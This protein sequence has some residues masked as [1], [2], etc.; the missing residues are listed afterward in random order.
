MKKKI[1]TTLMAGVSLLLFQHCSD[2]FLDVKPSTS[3]IVPTSL[4]D[5]ENLLDNEAEINQSGGLGQLSADEYYYTNKMHWEAVSSPS[6]RNAYIWVADLYEGEELIRDWNIPY[7]SIFYANSA[8]ETLADMPA[9]DRDSAYGKYLRGRALFTRAFA[10]FDLVKNFCV[11]YSPATADTDL[12]IPIRLSAGMDNIA[13]RSSLSDSYNAI[14][15]DLREAL[16]YLPSRF[17]VEKRNRPSGVACLALLARIYHHMGRY[18]LAEEHAN[19]CLDLY[20]QL[21]DYNA[22]DVARVNPFTRTNDEVIL[23]VSQVIGLFSTVSSATS[24]AGISVDTVLLALYEPDDLRLQA[25][26]GKRADGYTYKKPGYNDGNYPFTGLATDELYLI[27]AECLARRGAAAESMKTLNHLLR[28]RYKTGSYTQRHIVNAAEALEIVLKERR[29]ELVWRGIR[30][31]DLKRLN[32]EGA[33][34]SLKR[35]MD[36][37]SY[38]LPANSPRWVFPI[39]DAEINLSG[40]TQN[41]R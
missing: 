19:A 23:S 36:G 6:A 21:I 24:N 18:N 2:R 39:P 35:L 32:A 29:K 40:I 41:P 27:K 22:V 1:Y 5:I 10:H 14:L 7:T 34:I 4:E 17:D 37:N 11:A 13:G 3:L 38:E 26:Y 16:E 30:W 20:G 9:A 8:L 25:F 33:G 28:H 15:D 31:M 12:G